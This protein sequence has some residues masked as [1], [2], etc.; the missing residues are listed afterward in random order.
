MSAFL[1]SIDIRAWNDVI[2]GWKAPES[3]DDQGAMIGSK[4]E[5]DWSYIEDVAA[6]VNSCALNTIFNGVDMNVFI[7]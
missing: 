2:H 4:P 7:G 1:K 5:K 3:V 6:Q